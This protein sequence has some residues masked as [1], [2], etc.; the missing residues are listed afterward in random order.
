M[1]T[2]PTS[3]TPRVTAARTAP[4]TTRTRG[5]ARGRTTMG[6]PPRRAGGRDHMETERLGKIL[7]RAEKGA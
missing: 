1:T 6:P 4:E 5:T 2:L 7:V 3:M